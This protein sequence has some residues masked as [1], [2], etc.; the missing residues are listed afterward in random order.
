M[1]YHLAEYCSNTTLLKYPP[2]ALFYN[3]IELWLKL[4]VKVVL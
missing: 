1:I 4:G 2:I 3:Q